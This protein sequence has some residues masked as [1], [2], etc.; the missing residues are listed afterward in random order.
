MERYAFLIK[1]SIVTASYAF[2]D[3]S[4]SEIRDQLKA[5]VELRAIQDFDGH[6]INN[7][8]K[9]KG[10]VGDYFIDGQFVKPQYCAVLNDD[11]YCTHITSH[12]PNYTEADAAENEVLIHI[13]HKDFIGAY[14]DG[15]IWDF[16]N[17]M[18]PSN[19]ASLTQEEIE[20]AKLLLEKLQKL[21]L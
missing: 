5:L 1:D 19:L 10:G 17:R 13:N 20:V 14:Y 8:E 15:D 12:H 6:M 7:P 11:D 21:G 16:D 9:L 2:V 4:N 3:M 18:T